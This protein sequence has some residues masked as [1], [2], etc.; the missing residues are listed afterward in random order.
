MKRIAAWQEK[1]V[2]RLYQKG[3]SGLEVAR[4]LH[5]SLSQ[6]YDTLR[7]ENIKRR[8]SADQNRLRFERSPLSFKFRE[9]LSSKDQE[10][11][12]AGLML[13]YGEG[14][15]TNTTVDFANSDIFAVRLFLKF[16]RKIC[17]VDEKRLRFYLYCFSDQNPRRLI[18]TWSKQLKVKRSQFTRP[19]V[20]VHVG[21]DGHRIMPQG[22]LH[23]RYS[24]KRL[25]EKILFLSSRL[26]KNLTEEKGG[27]PQGGRGGRLEKIAA[28]RGNPKGA[29]PG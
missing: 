5:L 23:V 10:L 6:V 4:S 20:R 11:L 7:R 2:V 13:Y 28:F 21:R 12:V 29:R 18:D 19:Y 9:R 15:K 17:G 24:D 22:V 25:L 3:R 16:L 8:E 14:A 26:I 1:Q 27:G